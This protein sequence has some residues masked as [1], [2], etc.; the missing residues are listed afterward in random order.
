[1][2]WLVEPLFP[3]GGRNENTVIEEE[4]PPPLVIE[5]ADTLTK[6]ETRRAY[7]KDVQGFLDHLAIETDHQLIGV[8][9]QQ[10]AQW[11]DHLADELEAERLSYQSCKRRMAA[12]SSLF[13]YLNA[14]GHVI[15][16]PV[17][18]VRRPKRPESERRKDRR[19]VVEASCPLSHCPAV[20]FNGA[21]AGENPVPDIAGLLAKITADAQ[22]GRQLT[23]W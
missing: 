7:A 15:R 23:L 16:N 10:V 6:P 17:R 2:P 5:W 3:K 19:R 22:P 20:G 14:E 11:R 13:E 9:P 21:V 12:A 1:M 8:Q 4:G 18:R